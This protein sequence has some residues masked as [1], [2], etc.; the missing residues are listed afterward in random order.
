MADITEQCL[1]EYNQI[2]DFNKYLCHVFT[3]LTSEADGDR[4]MV[5]LVLKDNVARHWKTMTPEVQH[6]IMELAPAALQDPSLALREVCGSLI[7]VILA[8][9]TI[10]GWPH[11]VDNLIACLH[12]ENTNLVQGALTSLSLL[13]ED[14]GRALSTP[15]SNVTQQPTDLLIPKLYEIL[16]SNKPE[17]VDAAL[18]C[19][20]H[21]IPWQPVALHLSINDFFAV[22]FSLTH[23]RQE[24]SLRRSSNHSTLICLPIST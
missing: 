10:A 3:L 14:H 11:L 19:I 18:K 13:C 7:S 22:R 8:Q 17:M 4:M 2:S 24:T 9:T 20:S 12:D 6:Y 15:Q 1:T 16:Q 21:L 23:I 5:G